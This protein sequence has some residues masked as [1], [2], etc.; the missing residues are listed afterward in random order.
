MSNR[1]R[2]GIG[3]QKQQ[4]VPHSP[5]ML[6]CSTRERMP[7]GRPTLPPPRTRDL[8]LLEQQVEEVWEGAVEPKLRRQRAAQPLLLQVQ[9]LHRAAEQ[10]K[11]GTTVGNELA[12]RRQ[13]QTA[14]IT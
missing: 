9:R 14:G 1:S 8:V 7:G 10:G 12:A 6:R 11:A 3:S 2:G 5:C 4:G 13:H